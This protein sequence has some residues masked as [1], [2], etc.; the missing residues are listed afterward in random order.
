MRSWCPG[1]E[2]LKD[3]VGPENKARAEEYCWGREF[4]DLAYGVSGSGDGSHS[5]YSMCCS[6]WC[7]GMYSIASSQKMHRD[8]VQGG[9]AGDSV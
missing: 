4:V 5:S 9:G 1:N 6:D 8:N 2:G 7:R 3:L